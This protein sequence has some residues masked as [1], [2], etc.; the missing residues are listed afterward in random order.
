[1]FRYNYLDKHMFRLTRLPKKI[2]KGQ[3]KKHK[4]AT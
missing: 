3:H 1:M 2:K 4:I